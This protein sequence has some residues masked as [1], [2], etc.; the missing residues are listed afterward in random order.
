[1]ETMLTLQRHTTWFLR[2]AADIASLA[3]CILFG[4]LFGVAM[5]VGFD[6]RR[7]RKK[8]SVMKFN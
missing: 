5:L 8:P 7:C 2:I 1:M 4:K 6:E 3:P